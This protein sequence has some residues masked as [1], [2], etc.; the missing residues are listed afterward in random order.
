MDTSP[1]PEL[2]L[3]PSVLSFLS[4]FPQYLDIVVQCTRKTEVRSWRTLFAHLPPP[5]ELF[6]ESLQRGSLKTAGGYLLVLHTFEEL[7]SSSH[8]LIRLLQRAKLEQDW[9]LCK[10]LARF[11]MALDESG[12]TLREALEMAELT[13]PTEGGTKRPAGS[14]FMFEE[15]RQAISRNNG[16]LGDGSSVSDIGIGIGGIGLGT[17]AAAAAVSNSSMGSRSPASLVTTNGEGKA[18]GSSGG[19]GDGT[20]AAVAS[21]ETGNTTGTEADSS[22]DFFATGFG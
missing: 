2:A 8:Q 14:S 20:A 12:D 22:D 13:S 10:E 7:S 4:S 9:D 15:S 1:P 3:L 16:R 5:Q 6:E 18:S 11:L 21:H 17:A 19:D